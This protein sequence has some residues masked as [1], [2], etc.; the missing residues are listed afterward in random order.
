MARASLIFVLAMLIAGPWFCQDPLSQDRDAAAS[1][2]SA[3]HWLGT[4]DYGR[5]LLARYLHGGRWSVAAGAGATALALSLGWILGGAAGFLGGA[6]DS[7]V[8]TISEWFLAVPWLYMLIAARAALPLNLPPRSVSLAL[9]LLIAAVNW[10]RPAR[11]VR[12]LVLSLSAKGYVEA[13][14]GFGI[15]EW[16]IF[17]RHVLAGTA[18]LLTTQTLTLFPRFVLVEV[19]MSFLGVGASEPLPSWGGLIL[20]LKQVYLLPERPWILGPTLLMLPFFI[21]AAAV[22]IQT[23]KRYRVSR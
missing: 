2:P 21:G 10:A 6:A 3:K 19:T 16:T 12:G 11:L 23:E 14:R 5:D 1:G 8:M 7:L 17:W 22:A 9:I 15:P 13:A 4:D 18:G 20:P